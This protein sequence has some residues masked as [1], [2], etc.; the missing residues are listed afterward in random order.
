MKKIFSDYIFPFLMITV[1]AVLAAFAL[2][3][4]LIP[5]TILDGG[6]NGV[7]II[8]D[9]LTPINMSV[10]IIVLNLPF[11]L[12]G[13]KQ[14]GAM[15]FVR[16]IYGMVLFSVMLEVFRDLTNVTE[17]E[18][19]AVV[20][21]GM[22]L[23]AG[24]GLVLRYGGCLDGT[25]IVALLLSKK[26]SFSIGQIILGANI[27]IYAVAG[28]LF[29]WDRAMYSLL[30]YFITFKVIDIVEQ[31]M[32]QAKAIMVITDNGSY[33][34]DEIYKRL[35]RTCTKLEG[36]G[37]VSGK[38]DVLYC[39]ITRMEISGIKHIVH[40]SDS[41]AFVTVTD[42]S[43]IIGHHIKR[44]DSAVVAEVADVNEGA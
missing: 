23:G 8:L 29:G 5:S 44:T 16:G 10:F 30:A 38:K 4:F 19:L 3:E 1:G 11:L 26:T 31:G 35:G 37:L 33:I 18:L 13:L 39:V 42:V 12:V 20:F 24:V 43:E 36:S 41:S 9:K 27:I 22:M 15:F 14:L 28:I 17:T 2:E 34:A 7:S 21:G 6:I 40:S 25:E 32:E